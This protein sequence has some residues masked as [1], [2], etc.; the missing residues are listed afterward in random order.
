MVEIVSGTPAKILIIEDE[1]DIRDL[2]AYQLRRDGYTTF[3]TSDGYEGL[4]LARRE[5]PEVI[6]LDLML[7]GLSG[8][9]VCR[10]LRTEQAAYPAHIIIVSAL[11]EEENMVR[12][13]HLGAD[14]Y[15]GK[16]FRVREVLARVK[17]V[18]RR[19]PWRAPA[20]SPKDLLVC[21]PL[22]LDHLRRD[23]MLAGA[24]LVL[25]ASEYRLLHLLMRHPECVFT[26]AQLA[27]AITGQGLD[28]GR[29]VDV[30]ICSL[31]QKLGDNAGL[32]DTV[33]GVGYRLRVQTALAV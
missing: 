30:H 32:I 4:A 24:P 6:L 5:H 27:A 12:G 31:R 20:A 19:I 17:A 26:R 33:R 22:T 7:P 14:D 29:N 1:E 11:T 21:H 3:A 8:W 9:D 23:V 18:Q 15:V 10:Q 25:T 16:P 2:L 13:L 28:G